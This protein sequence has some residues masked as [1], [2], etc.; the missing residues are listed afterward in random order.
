MNVVSRRS[1]MATS[2][3]R[4]FVV[5]LRV[6][7]VAVECVWEVRCAVR[8]GYK[9]R[10]VV[11]WRALAQVLGEG[12]GV[13]REKGLPLRVLASRLP[14]ARGEREGRRGGAASGRTVRET[15]EEETTTEGPRARSERS[16]PEGA[17]RG[18]EGRDEEWE[19]EESRRNGKG[20]GEMRDEVKRSETKG[21]DR[22]RR[23][24]GAIE[25]RRKGLDATGG[26]GERGSED[27]KEKKR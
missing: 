2:G 16:G 11:C 12:G 27:G 7:R 13:G 3:P 22:G 14:S 8:V 24:R 5:Q 20:N 10:S 19:E 4:A 1:R 15:N 25:T 21:L 26:R 17:K 23:D 9:A 6:A 18:N